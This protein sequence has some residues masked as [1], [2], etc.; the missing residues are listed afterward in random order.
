MQEPGFQFIGHPRRTKE[1]RRFVAGQGRFVAD[2]R[3]PGMLECAL[4]TSPY[5]RA[6]IVAV[7]SEAASALRGV[8]EVLAGPA[9]AAQVNPLTHGIDVPGIVWY[10]LAVDCARY[11]GEWVA[12]VVAEDRYVAEDAAELVDVDYDPATAVVDPEAALEADSPVVHEAHGSN[13]LYHRTFIW[14]DVDADFQNAANRLCHRVCWGR[15]STVP[16]ETFGV[17]ASHDPG[18]DL[19]DIWASIQMPKFSEQIAAALGIPHSNV[20]VHYDVDVGGSY[21]VKR[22]LKHAVLTGY[23]ARRLGRPILLWTMNGHPLGCT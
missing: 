11:V 3:L 21:G 20:R 16:I 13:V 8:R 1:G 14:K 7:N 17:V 10:P 6:R 15:S 22:G 4:V 18:T 9:L 5:P 23:L 19:L 12:V 2:I